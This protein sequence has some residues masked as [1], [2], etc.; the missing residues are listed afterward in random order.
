MN[1]GIK[2]VTF[3]DIDLNDNF[4]KSL[5]ADYKEFPSWYEKKRNNHED[6]YVQY[7][8]KGNL[9]GFLYVK[10]EE[11]DEI[12]DINPI[13]KGERITKIG[14]FKIDAHG[15]R[16]GEQFLKIVFDYVFE[17]DSKMVYVTVFEKQ[18]A[19][20]KLFK[21]FGFF[22]WGIKQSKN[23][24][25]KVFVKRFNALDGDIIKDYP[26]V[27]VK[28]SKKYLLS[29]YPKYH[30]VMF[31]ESILTNENRNLIKDIS[32]TN[33]IEKVYVCAMEGV[34]KLKRGDLLLIYRTAE[35][36]RAAEY[37]AVA[38]TVCSVIEVK[39]Q[40]DF[41]DFDKF[42]SYT[43]KYTVF[44]RD[45]LLYWYNK[46]GLFIIRMNYNFAL[47]KRIVRHDLIERFGIERDQYWGFVDLTDEQFIEIIK[48]GEAEKYLR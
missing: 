11:K 30:S 40:Q 3:T 9:R 43:N 2:H 35:I 45:D 5:I 12:T 18:D 24:I 34:S 14:T 4:F 32:Y 37:S 28:N 17:N 22:E 1:E 10:I 27:N 48:A 36:G 26:L 41:D 42:Y 8:E 20:I 39:K 33:S 7:D 31:P 29:I 44:D 23:G 47:K 25:E 21:K 46:G 6:A 13:L 19:L 38:S 16:M 15:T